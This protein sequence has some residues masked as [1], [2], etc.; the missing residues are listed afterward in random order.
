M[1]K[2]AFRG[3]VSCVLMM[4]FPGSLFAADSNA[5]MLY[6]NGA[7]WVNGTHVPRTSS[8][9]FYGDLLQTRSDSVANIN[10]AGSSITILADSLV[11]FE[12]TSLDIDHGGVMVSTSRSV[13]TTAGDVKVTPVSNSWTEF[14]VTDLDGKVRISAKKGD[15]NVNNGKETVLLAQ[16]QE[17]TQ[18]D[19]S[20]DDQDGK[21]KK[22]RKASGAVPAAGGGILNSPWAIGAGGA[23]VIGVTTWVLIQSSNPASP[24][25]P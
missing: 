1:R 22:K 18:D 24:A 15:L 7:A 16:G 4:V 17:T 14:N 2:S 5:A 23:A 3:L 13:A 12:G 21:K 9:I 25:K 10:E 19:S 8:A 20:N 11:T 6:T